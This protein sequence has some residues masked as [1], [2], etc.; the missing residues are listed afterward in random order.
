MARFSPLLVG[1]GTGHAERLPRQPALTKETGLR[2]NGNHRLLDVFDT[3]V[4][5]TLPLW[6]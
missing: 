6:M 2:Q 5:F 1:A 4:S 3:T